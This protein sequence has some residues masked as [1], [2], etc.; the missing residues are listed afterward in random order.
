[1]P[2]K[3]NARPTQ[4]IA[5]TCSPIVGVSYWFAIRSSRVLLLLS[6][7][8]QLLNIVAPFREALPLPFTSICR[9]FALEGT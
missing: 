5:K 2:I 1:M 4:R 9:W 6:D 3:S 7:V 8:F